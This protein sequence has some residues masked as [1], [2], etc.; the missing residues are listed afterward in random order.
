M[1]D[2]DLATSTYVVNTKS[3]VLIALTEFIS[4]TIE[5]KFERVSR[6][7][8]LPTVALVKSCCRHIEN[9]NA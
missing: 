3:L 5:L 8:V 2:T 6:M 1:E 7:F 9:V 4:Q